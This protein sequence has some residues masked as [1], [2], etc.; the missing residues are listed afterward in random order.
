MKF[1][2]LFLFTFVSMM[3]SM[4]AGADV[5][6]GINYDFVSEAERTVV[7]V[8][9]LDPDLLVGDVKIP[10]KVIIDGKEYTVTIISGAAFTFC[11]KMTSIAIP[12]TVQYI[13]YGAFE[14]LDGL[15]AVYLEDIAAWCSVNL[16]ATNS[17]PISLAHHLFVNGEE[18]TELVI[19][20]GVTSIGNFAFQGASAIISVVIPSSV[21]AI[22]I[23]TFADCTALKDVYCY[24]ETVPNIQ[25]R[26]FIGTDL[27]NVTLHVPATSVDQYKATWTE[28]K[29][30][31]PIAD[32]TG[33][34]RLSTDE[35]NGE[36]YQL[37]GQRATSPKHGLNI[38]RM[39]DG[40]S[41]KVVYRE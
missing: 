10:S 40:T 5:Y 32:V 33:V 23:Y 1:T 7:V 28:F 31:V 14:G 12:P 30:V 6:E 20:D 4:N 35:Q 15:E 22:G 36:W 41:K 18:V 17:N 16:V 21:E 37:N 9:Q 34:E 27:S 13:E 29:D 8:N 11:N 25:S 2:K 26:S 19:P 38:I 3:W 24:A 39:K